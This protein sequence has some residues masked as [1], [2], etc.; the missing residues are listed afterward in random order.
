MVATSCE[1]LEVLDNTYQ[2][3][4]SPILQPR[5]SVL[6]VDEVLDVDWTCHIN[7]TYEDGSEAVVKTEVTDKTADNL[8]W[9]AALTPTQTQTIILPT[10]LKCINVILAIEI[11]NSTVIP[12]FKKE[13][14]YILPIMTQVI[15]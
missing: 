7:A 14:H 8:R 15:S 6:A 4:T 9:I 11:A 5:P 10:G 2:G 3:D 13:K 1:V 12:P